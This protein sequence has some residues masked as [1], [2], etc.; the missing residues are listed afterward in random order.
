MAMDIM[1]PHDPAMTLPLDCCVAQPW[2]CQG[3]ALSF[4]DLPVPAMIEPWAFMSLY[5][6]AM[7]LS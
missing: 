3:L 4:Q 5:G 7:G 2:P 6:T 1:T